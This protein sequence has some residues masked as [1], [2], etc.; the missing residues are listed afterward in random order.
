MFVQFPCTDCRSAEAADIVFLIDESWTVGQEN[1]QIIKDFIRSMIT[2]FQNTEVLGREG[3][4][5]GVAVYGDS[6]R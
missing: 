6:T 4:R 1:F 5:F 2:S 3:I